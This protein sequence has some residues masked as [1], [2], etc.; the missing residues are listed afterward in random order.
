MAQRGDMEAVVSSIRVAKRMLRGK[1][2]RLALSGPTHPSCERDVASH[3]GY[4]QRWRHRCRHRLN[5]QIA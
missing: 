3:A 4:Q 5:W 2:G 1:L